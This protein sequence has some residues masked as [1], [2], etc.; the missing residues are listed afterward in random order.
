MTGFERWSVLTALFP[1]VDIPNRKPRPVLVLSDLGFNRSH[2][3]FIAAM[4]TTAAAGR[5]PSD[6]PILDLAAAG[7]RTPSVVRWKLF[8]LPHGVVGKTIG[9]MAQDDR[10]A[11]STRL[12]HI[13]L[14]P[15]PRVLPSSS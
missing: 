5:W 1:F 9:M 12:G 2:D 15:D 3:V 6:H 14:P 10:T 4:I 11:V 7:L 13:L 8:T